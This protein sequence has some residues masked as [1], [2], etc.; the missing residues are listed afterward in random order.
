M[1]EE[2]KTDPVD[3]VKEEEP[4]ESRPLETSE[5]EEVVGG[6]GPEREPGGGRIPDGWG[7][8]DPDNPWSIP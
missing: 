1:P 4:T 2:K 3:E 7:K 5:L 8:P 6:H